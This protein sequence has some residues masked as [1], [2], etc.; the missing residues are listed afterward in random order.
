VY[1]AIHNL[2]SLVARFFFHVRLL[3]GPACL[4]TAPPQDGSPCGRGWGQP[5]EEN[6][7]TFFAALLER[8]DVDGGGDGEHSAGPAAAT[9]LPPAGGGE[10]DQSNSRLRDPKRSSV[11]V[12]QEVKEPR[13]EEVV[14]WCWDPRRRWPVGRRRVGALAHPVRRVLQAVAGM[15]LATLLQLMVLVGA[16]I[17]TFGQAY[18]QLLL[19][20]YGGKAVEQRKGKATCFARAGQHPAWPARASC[21]YLA[22]Q[23]GRPRVATRVRYLRSYHGGER[24]H[25]MLCVCGGSRPRAHLVVTGGESG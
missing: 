8:C 4:V 22:Q 9:K 24:H 17:A 13:E 2:G 5:I 16:V 19:H 18:A 20:L 3:R 7:Y 6:Y 15:T 23:R 10:T 12:V 14:C 25:R 21:R 11:A 1:D